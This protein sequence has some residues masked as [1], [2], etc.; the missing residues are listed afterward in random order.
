ME[1]QERPA[2]IALAPAAI[3]LETVLPPYLMEMLLDCTPGS[4]RV[5]R[6]TWTSNRRPSIVG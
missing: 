2:A 6:L 4:S 3:R 1:C 5:T